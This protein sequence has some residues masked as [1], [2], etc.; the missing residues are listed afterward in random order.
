M[1]EPQGQRSTP[2][3]GFQKTS[4]MDRRLREVDHRLTTSSADR[5]GPAARLLKS[6]IELSKKQVPEPEPQVGS[7]PKKKRKSATGTSRQPPLMLG[8]PDH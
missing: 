4:W 1:S 2:T 5:L 8:V 3:Q 7:P 6:S